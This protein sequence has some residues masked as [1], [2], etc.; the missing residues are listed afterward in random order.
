[1][2]PIEIILDTDKLDTIDDNT[3]YDNMIFSLKIWFRRNQKYILGSFILIILAII[4]IVVSIQKQ[5]E[6]PCL[7]Y[8]PDTLA[9]SVSVKCLQFLWNNA[10]CIR[11]GNGLIPDNYSGFYL[12]SPNGIEYVHCDGLHTGNNCGVGS[13]S[14]MVNFIQSCNL[15]RN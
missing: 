4:I 8:S 10:G 5:P 12:N 13:Y 14:R 6:F 15:Y 2:K 3:Y 9:S 1:M 11:R 7:M